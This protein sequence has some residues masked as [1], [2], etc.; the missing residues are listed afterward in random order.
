MVSMQFQL[1]DKSINSY[2]ILVLGI[3]SLEQL[4]KEIEKIG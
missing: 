4:L 2:L 1:R 3:T